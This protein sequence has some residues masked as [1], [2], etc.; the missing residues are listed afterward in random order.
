MNLIAK[1]L[2]LLDI[3]LHS[4]IGLGTL[5][6]VVGF[7]VHFIDKFSVPTATDFL[8]GHLVIFAKWMLWIFGVILIIIGVCML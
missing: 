1:T 7:I 6:V 3:V 5:C 4:M 8:F 2:E